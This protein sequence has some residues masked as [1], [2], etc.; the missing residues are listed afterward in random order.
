MRSFILLLSIPFSLAACNNRQPEF[1]ASGAFEAEE[2]IVSAEAAGV[3]KALD[4]EEGR[5]LPATQYIGYI[6]STQA[7]LRKEQLRAQIGAVESRKPNTGAQLAALQAQLETARHEQRRM[8]NLVRADAAT[9]KQLDDATAQ[10]TILQRQ[11]E[12]QR[13]SLEISTGSIGQEALPLQVQVR[14]A[15][16]QLA[17]YRL[18]NPIAGTVLAK[19]AAAG[20]LANPGKPL[21]KIA[22][23]ASLWLRAYISASQLSQLK[24]GQGVKVLTDDGKSKYKE[25][26]GTL[27]WISSKAEFTPKSIQTK[28]E[29]AS[30][31]YAVKIKV[32]NDGTLKIGMYAEVKF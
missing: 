6:D 28:E 27:T 21:Y 20:E 18:V 1:D 2:V 13:S 14:Q 23:M 9:P 10:V 4:I 5:I 30:T 22:D 12:A 17:K 16:D 32:I 29:R 31:V 7:Y 15:A 26:E 19:Y 24:L 11:I 25:H 3:I 8:A